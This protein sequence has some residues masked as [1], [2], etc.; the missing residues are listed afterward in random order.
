M[1]AINPN[2]WGMLISGS[3]KGSAETFVAWIVVGLVIGIIASKI[4]NK[5]GHGR[6]RDVLLGIFGAIVGGFLSNLFGKSGGSGLDFYSLIVAAVGAVVFM[7]VY[8]ALFRRRRFLSMRYL[9][10]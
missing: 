9:R 2:A 10:R 3:Q 5:T 1:L 6:I 7:L 4:L 8:H